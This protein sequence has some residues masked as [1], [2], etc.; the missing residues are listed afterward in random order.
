[1]DLHSEESN[2]MAINLPDIETVERIRKRAKLNNVQKKSPLKKVTNRQEQIEKEKI[3]EALREQRLEEKRILEEEK[4]I[5]KLEKENK[6]IEKEKMKKEYIERRLEEKRL[7]EEERALQL[8]I[9]AE[10][11][12]KRKLEYQIMRENQKKQKLDEKRIAEEETLKKRKEQALKGMNYLLKISSKYSDFFKEKLLVDNK[13]SSA[14]KSLQE[15]NKL[16]P[17]LSDMKEAVDAKIQSP[18]VKAKNDI[19]QELK[20]FEGGSLREYQIEGVQWMVNLLNNGINGIL[21]DEMGLGKTVQII[22]LIAHLMEIK[23]PGPFLIIAPLS[24][25]P[26]WEMEFQRF[27]PRI[28][29]VVFHGNESQRIQMYSEI[30]RRYKVGDFWTRP[31]VLTTYQTPVAEQKILKTL[32]WQYIIIDEGHRVKNHECQLAVMLRSLTSS[33]RLLLTGTPIHN[34]ITELWALLNFLMPH[35][36]NH[37]DTFASLVMLEDMKDE[38]KLIEQ[39]EKTNFITTLHRVLEPF[40]LRR[41]KKDVLGDVVPKKELNIY[42]PLTK[43]QHDLYNYVI[44]KNMAKLLRIEEDAPLPRRGR[45][46]PKSYYEPPVEDDYSDYEEELLQMERANTKQDL[47]KEHIKFITRITMMSPMSMFKKIVDHPYLVHFPLDPDADEKTLLI[48]EDLICSSGKLMVLDQLLPRLKKDGHKVLIF[49]TLVMSLDLIEE[50]LIMREYKYCRLDGGMNLINR[51]H[52]IERFSK[53]PDMFVFLLSTRSGGL[54]LNL[55]AADT[56]IFF[57]RDWNPQMDIQAQDRCHRIGQTKPV[58]V[59]TLVAKNTI[60]DLII[61]RGYQKRL[62]EKIIIQDGKFRKS[63]ETNKIKDELIT[64]QKLLK[65]QTTNFDDLTIPEKELDRLLDRSELWAMMNK[66]EM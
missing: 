5:R 48:N 65:E 4:L 16:L 21:A 42:C 57:D 22:A 19:K 2:D 50:A 51:K 14:T 3:R 45:R 24:T 15:K 63:G 43:L 33:N 30:Q 18:V 27:A 10:E 44:N 55:T 7:Q 53:D 64:L 25:I 6:K 26:N 62:L 23:V 37:V 32:E 13:K 9:Q 12:M 47:K 11:K 39:E 36:F 8:V 49:S 38:N 40:V 66:K 20:L 29:V 41:L 46:K 34:N 52:N 28:P 17:T 61:N 1:M 54:G 59:Y 35:I 60:D 58:M 31:V 56:V